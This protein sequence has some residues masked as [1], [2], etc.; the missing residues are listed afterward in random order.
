MHP[1][2]R[3]IL[4]L[5]YPPRCEACGLLRREPI[6]EE[7]RAAIELVRPPVCE[8]CG[9]PFDPRARGAPTCARCRRGGQRPFSVARSAAYYE[10]PLAKAIRRFKYEGQLVVGKPLGA[11]MVEGLAGEAAEG[12]KPET[13]DVVCAVPRHASRLGGRGF[14]QSE[15]L[16]EA[17]AGAIGKPL[18]A[19][20]ERTRPTLPQVDLPAASR[21]GNVR[22]A[23]AARLTE[24][25]EGQRV[26][27]IDDLFTTGA[28]MRECA[29]VLRRSGAG[30]VR[31]FALAR[32]APQWR[33]PGA[34]I[35]ADA[36]EQRVD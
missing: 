5:L 7:C 19:L 8:V 30:E 25:I 1:F 9:E 33:R 18:K 28:T 21:A 23:F 24:V 4:D 3:G 32:A 14:N 10:G 6:C 29:R 15:V 16:A 17:V 35:R 27:L 22:G 13:V 11:I 26:L 20:L 36:R 2:W 12:L 31:V 34:E